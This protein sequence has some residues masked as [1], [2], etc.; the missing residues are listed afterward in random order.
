VS[1]DI[2]PLNVQLPGLKHKRGSIINLPFD[3]NSIESLSSLCVIEHIGL[4]RYGDPFDP[5]GSVRA[6]RELSRVLLPGGNLYVSLPV[7]LETKTIFNAHRIFTTT[8]AIALFPGLQLLE[9][10][11]VGNNGVLPGLAS[12]DSSDSPVILLHLTKPV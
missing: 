3:D 7:G 5:L 11:I 9:R 2:R 10:I 1:V 4:G 12:V 6:G 8:D